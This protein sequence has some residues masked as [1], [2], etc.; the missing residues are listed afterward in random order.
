MSCHAR[1]AL[2]E[3]AENFTRARDQI[4]TLSAT[5]ALRREDLRLQV[6]LITPLQYVKG[7]RAPETK[8]A[9]ERALLLIKQ[10]EALGEQPEDPLLLFLVLYRSWISNLATSTVTRCAKSQHS[11]WRTR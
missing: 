4:A 11:F 8:M 7:F 2:V 6:A 5:P 1:S 3:A 9:L 10:A